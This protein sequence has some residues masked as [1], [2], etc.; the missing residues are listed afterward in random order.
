MLRVH[1]KIR[2][3]VHIMSYNVVHIMP[4]REII[5]AEENAGDFL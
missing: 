2:N 1:I 5:R 4:L 3:V